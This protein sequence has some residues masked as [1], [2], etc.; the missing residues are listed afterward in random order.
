VLVSFVGVGLSVALM[1]GKT[2]SQPPGIA[3]TDPNKIVRALDVFVLL[4]N[5]NLLF[6]HFIGASMAAW[7][8]NQAL[9]ARHRFAASRTGGA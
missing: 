3:I 2:V 9:R 6:G 7:L 1:I 4:V 8:S 5:I